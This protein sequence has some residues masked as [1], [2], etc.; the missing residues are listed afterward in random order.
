M[1]PGGYAGKWLDV[2]LTKDKIKEVEY[3]DKILEQ[4]FGGRGLAAKVLWDKVGDKYPELDPK[5]RK[6][7]L[8][9]MES[10]LAESEQDNEMQ[11]GRS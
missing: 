11:Q 6:K 1:T 4:Y 2:D 9:Q 3:G 10:I 8:E 5:Q 7:I